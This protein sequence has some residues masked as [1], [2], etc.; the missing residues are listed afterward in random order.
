MNSSRIPSDARQTL[1]VEFS[2]VARPGEEGAEDGRRTLNKSATEQAPS[3][4]TRRSAALAPFSIEEV[5]ETD[6]IGARV[7]GWRK[8]TEAGYR[9]G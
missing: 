4:Q 3:K 7:R 8:I 2:R 9:G 5:R 6:G 1:G